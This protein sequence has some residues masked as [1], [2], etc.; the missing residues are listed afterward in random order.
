M[1]EHETFIKDSEGYLKKLE[2]LIPIVDRVHGGNHPEFH[3]VRELFGLI[4][5]KTN[6][7]KTGKPNIDEEIYKL[8][9]LTA[10]YKVPSDV[11]E[12]YEEVYIMLAKLDEIYS[13]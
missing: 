5:N 13:K 10:N 2:Q 9:E 8:R 12:S 1:K 7:S 11:C 6:V 4:L 3:E